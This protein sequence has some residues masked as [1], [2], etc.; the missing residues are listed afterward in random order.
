[1]IV[2]L[3]DYVQYRLRA[4]R[5]GDHQRDGGMGALAFVGSI[6]EDVVAQLEP[7]D[8]V[9]TQRLDSTLSWATMYFGSSPVDHMAIYVGDG[10]VIHAT[11][12][13]VK[14]HTLKVL[15]LNARVLIVKD[16]R[17]VVGGGLDEQPTGGVLT[18]R[19]RWFHSLPPKGQ[20]A[21]VAIEIVLGFYPASFRWKF[22]A[23][24]VF[25]CVIIDTISYWLLNM[26]FALPAAF[27]FGCMIA[28]NLSFYTIRKWRGKSYQLL[29]H[30]DI[31]YRNFFRYGGRMVTKLGT[32]VVCDLGLVPLDLFLAYRKRFGFSGQ[33]SDD[34]ADDKLQEPS[35][36]GG[37]DAEDGN[38]EGVFSRSE[39]KKGNKDQDK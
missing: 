37:N 36:F 6:P 23:D 17:S 8:V 14:M 29:S 10:N 13:G 24:V 19:E 22:F 18:P 33:G 15:A 32:L 21:M 5:Y 2:A 1:M 3:I 31:G 39:D 11:L 25:I 35:E 16:P 30:P 12:G 34:G 26:Y 9:F 20:L 38:S 7:G 28:V 4:G 27:I